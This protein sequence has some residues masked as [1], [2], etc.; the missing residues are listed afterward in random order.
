[1]SNVGSKL[2][3]ILL[4]ILTYII[5]EIIASTKHAIFFRLIIIKIPP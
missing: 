4:K 5:V 1:M 2:P 3:N